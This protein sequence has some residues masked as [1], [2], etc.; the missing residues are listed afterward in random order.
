[1]DTYYDHVSATYARTTKTSHYSTFTAANGYEAVTIDGMGLTIATE[2]PTGMVGTAL[3]MH[4]ATH[5]YDDEKRLLSV[6]LPIA[7]ASGALLLAAP[8]TVGT[9]V[10]RIKV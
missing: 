7:Q 6:T 4:S 2:K 10:T 1:V 3:N 9:P 5:V 8:T